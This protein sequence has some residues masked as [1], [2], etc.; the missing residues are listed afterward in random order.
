[1]DLRIR[2][3]IFRFAFKFIGAALNSSNANQWW[4][5][6]YRIFIIHIRPCA[7]G[8][9]EKKYQNMRCPVADH[10]SQNRSLKFGES[11]IITHSLRPFSPANVEKNCTLSKATQCKKIACETVMSNWG[12]H[13]SSIAANA[14]N[15][16]NMCSMSLMANWNTC[17]RDTQSD[18]YFELYRCIYQLLNGFKHFSVLVCHANA[19]K[20]IP[21]FV[22][23]WP[24]FNWIPLFIRALIRI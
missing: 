2:F 3:G 13:R 18:H 21:Y 7:L 16:R 14:V 1:M 11:L 20:F 8:T 4:V 22:I 9:K 23:M 17:E 10:S 15:F 6:H 19:R 12:V 24:K 5:K